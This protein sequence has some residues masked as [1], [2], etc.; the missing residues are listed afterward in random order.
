MKA[1][2]DHLRG[3]FP[4]SERHACELMN[5]AVSTFRYRTLRSDAE[6]KGKLVE[7]SRDRPRFGYRRLLVL[8]RRDG[9]NLNHKRVWRVYREVGLN[10]PLRKRKRLTRVSCPL[11]TGCPP[12]GT[13]LSEAEY[14]QCEKSAAGDD[15]R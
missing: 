4:V 10:V 14:A 15:R 5:V 1:D 12:L 3:S 8:L 9:E 11:D 7:L 13:K 6:L 2:V